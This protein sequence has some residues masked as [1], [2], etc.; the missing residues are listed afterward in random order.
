MPV[1][2][3]VFLTLG[4]IVEIDNK[5]EREYITP[6]LAIDV[7]ILTIRQDASFAEKRWE[8]GCYFYC[9]LKEIGGN[10]FDQIFFPLCFIAVCLIYEKL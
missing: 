2:H 3:G 9:F 1:L 10:V 8:I 7:E 5:I 6:L 4:A